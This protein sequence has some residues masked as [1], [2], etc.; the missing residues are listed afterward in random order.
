MI[1]PTL[2]AAPDDGPAVTLSIAAVERETGIPKDTLRVWER[3]YG[4]PRPERNVHGERCYGSADI[5]R[6]RLIRQLIDLGYRPARIVPAPVA[7]LQALTSLQP[8]PDA[9]L[10]FLLALIRQHDMAALRQAFA[11]TIAADGL[12]EFVRNTAAPLADLVGQAWAEGSMAIFEEHLFSETLQNVLRAALLKLDPAPG[13]PRVLLATLPDEAH[14]LGL[15]MAQ[16]EISL[17]GGECIS[18]GVQTPMTEIVL[19]ARAGRVDVVALSSSTAPAAGALLASVRT[20]REWLPESVALWVGGQVPGLRRRRLPGVRLIPNLADVS[21]A[22]LEV[23]QAAHRVAPD[24][25]NAAAN[26]A[27]G[28][29]CTVGSAA[30]VANGAMRAGQANGERSPESGAVRGLDPPAAPLPRR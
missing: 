18:L 27:A 15:L 19:A 4:Y 9:R 20:L 6:L 23:R 11:A 24:A 30:G 25:A 12:S 26:A 1:D 22:L 7:A 10:Q 17:A 3:R 28:H 21:A 5:D 2:A 13:A 29:A 16:A 14:G 8:V